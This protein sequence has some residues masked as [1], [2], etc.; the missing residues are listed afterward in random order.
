MKKTGLSRATIYKQMES[1]ELIWEST[2]GGGKKQ[3]RVEDDAEVLKL[4]KEIDRVNEKID[5]LMKHLGVKT[6]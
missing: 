4:M 2:N 6:A 5:K 1:G 3:I